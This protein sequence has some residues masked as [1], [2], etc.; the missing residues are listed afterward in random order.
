MHRRIFAPGARRR[1]IAL[2]LVFAACIGH[3][4][5]GVAAEAKAPMPR[6][7]QRD[8]RHAFLVDDRPFLMLSGQVN[9]SSNYPAVLPQVWPAI[10]QLHANT[11][12]VPIAWEQIEPREG[13]FDF[14]FLDT[15]L[16]QAREQGVRLVL[17]WFATWKNNNLMY[18]PEWV[19]LDNGKYPRV[20]NSKGER[21]GSLSPLGKATL[22]ADRKAF[23]A[24]MRHLKE[25]DPQRTVILIQVQNETGTYGSVRD[26][27][28]LA[29][30]A[31][32]AQVPAPLVRAL[33][34][35]PGTWPQV[36]GADADEFFH[37]WHI[38]N[39]VEQVAAA[40]KAEYPLPMYVNAALRDPLKPSPPSTYSSGGP[41]DNVLDVWKAAA[42]SI[43]LIAP[44]IYMKEYDKYLKVLELY[45]RKDNALFVAETGNA[46]PFAR[47]FF[48]TLGHQGIGFSPFGMDF[49][50]YS[51]FPLGAHKLDEDT[52]A[53]FALSYRLVAPM[54]R[55]LAELS[56]QGKVHAVS[57]NPAQHR[58]ELAVLGPWKI[59]VAYGLPQFG[60]AEPP[61]NPE[62]VGGALVAQLAPDEF[63]VTGCH[64]R[65]EFAVTDKSGGKK[66]QF[67]RVEEGEY[68]N[69][70]WEFAR[71]WNGDQID[72]GLN[73]TSAPQVLRVRVA[74]Y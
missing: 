30:R 56:Y 8:G 50:G 67:L 23:V 35:K 31:F 17:L 20:V 25:I 10:R 6:F 68:Q 65:V 22:A 49:T 37:A 60:N 14:S 26:Y 51:N 73:F 11:V 5:T 54:A 33:R 19:K 29:Q 12:Q 64:A 32:E 27:S 2:N 1:L 43:D 63:L 47:Y 4:A 53:H 36:F 13:Q 46:V 71:V 70:A 21:M 3:P 74:T 45:G 16:P 48:A 61:G 15:L 41:T 52:L 69:G 9:N 62:P 57:E 59:T 44:D 66:L 42:P 38:A 40:G 72:W 28:P 18:A 34:K 55:E 58:Q 7:I 24:L 39:F